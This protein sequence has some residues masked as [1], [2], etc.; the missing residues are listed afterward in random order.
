MIGGKLFIKHG[1]KTEQNSQDENLQIFHWAE[2]H[3]SSFI[4][5]LYIYNVNRHHVR[6][7]I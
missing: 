1:N 7:L 6:Y 5:M 3:H 4:M 2:A